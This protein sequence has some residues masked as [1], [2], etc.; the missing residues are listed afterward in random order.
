VTAFS[1]QLLQGQTTFPSNGAPYQP[2]S[3]YALINANL[4]VDA[5]HFISNGKLVFQDGKIIASGAA[6][7][8]PEGAIVMDLK[9]KY[10]YPA[11]ID[12]LSN[13]G[14]SGTTWPRKILGGPQMETSVKGAY[15]WNMAI[16]SDLQA[17]QIFKHNP[18]AAEE[19]RKAG[20]GAVL[21]ASGDGIVR[22]SGALVLLNANAKENESMVS[23]TAAA[24]YSFDKGS[25]TQDYPSSLTGAIALLRQTFYDAA[26][27][28]QS[29]EQAERNIS[30]E[31]MSRLQTLPAIVDVNDKYQILRVSKLSQ[32]FKIPFIVKAGGNEYQRLQEIKASN[33][34]L[35]VPLDFPTALDVEDPY[36]AEN[37]SLADLK[38]WEL[39]P[40]NP[41][42]L[43]QAG[44]SFALSTAD[45]KDKN[46]FLKNLRKSVQF[47]LSESAALKA[48][49]IVPAT[50]LGLENKIGTLNKGLL[51]NFI[52]TNK[53]LFEDDAIV[54]ENWSGGQRS[55]Y[56][57]IDAPD[58][59]GVYELKV[60][61]FVYDLTLSG[62]PFQP[63]ATLKLDTAKKNVSFHWNGAQINFSASPDSVISFRASGLYQV[64]KKLIEGNAQLQDGTWTNFKMKFVHAADTVQ[65]KKE[66]PKAAMDLGEVYYPFSAYGQ[67]VATGTSNFV[68]DF[69]KSKKNYTSLLIKNVSIWTNEKE[70]LLKEQDVLVVGDRIQKIGKNLTAPAGAKIIDGTGKHL[71][72]GI[73]D[74][75]SH[76]ALTGGVNESAE[77]ST[78]EVR[79][80]DVINPEDINIYRQLS[81]GV[82]AAQL[83]HGSANPIGGQSAIIKL[84]WGLS[85]E[86]LKI[87]NAVPFIK[88]ALGENVKQSNWGDLNSVRFPQS[89]MGVEQV[90]VDLFTRAMAYD[91]SQAAFK[92]AK[93]KT[94]A[95]R[96]DLELEALAEILNSKRFIT[97]HSYVQSEINMLM[98]V[99][100]T[101]GFRVNT[102]TH[103][104]EGYKVAD[105]MK[106]HGVNASTFSDWWAYKNEVMDAIPYNAAVLTRMGVVTAI[107]SDDAEMARR[108]NQEAAKSVKYGALTEEEALKMVTLNPAIMLHLDKEIGS[109]K[110]GKSAD[111]VLWSDNPLSVYAK[112]EMTIIEG[113]IYFDRQQDAQLRAQIITERARL[114][115][116]LL[117]EKL[118]G[119]PV[120]KPRAKRQQL[121]H[122]N[123]LEGISETET[124]QR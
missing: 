13:Y 109:I 82:T 107:N 58:I 102:F 44:I 37:V 54:L 2:H 38:H 121:Y 52:I 51:A 88:F 45:L 73:I 63:K 24:L 92:L 7:T 39:A 86:D 118:K 67:A 97:C 108:L 94:L 100:D 110:V 89:R 114:I 66:V 31:E 68:A 74:E 65:K 6:V 10:V 27:Y 123:T 72:P 20:F 29:K 12:L 57:N 19:Y 90:Y 105:K 71:T 55:A 16:R 5:E 115:N 83:L 53:S 1:L 112:A 80:G 46:V 28:N 40:A 75:H 59:R 8:V 56:S 76:I 17:Y 87:S 14:I 4:F 117:A 93:D 106:A 35:I 9:G 47:G 41:K 15:G 18:D 85:A 23:E 50:Y 36:D 34:R 96:R 69:A 91:K 25:S 103:I 119:T 120:V 49:T 11:F 95:P 79:M 70:G 98:H 64:D 30:L 116:K 104:L 81:G 113:L 61:A 84:R 43:E 111:L 26:W 33:L 22:G 78:A 62:D 60:G 124:G 3:V 77:A 122:C 101:F 48:L 99:A 42:F 32:E 21:S